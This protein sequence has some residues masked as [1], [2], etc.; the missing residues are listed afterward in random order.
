MLARTS[1]EFGNMCKSL[2]NFFIIFRHVSSESEILNGETDK[3][4]HRFNCN[5]KGK[6]V[7]PMES[8]EFK[9]LLSI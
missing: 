6:E 9:P 7:K 5:S 2:K 8:I 3:F 4:R 1:Q